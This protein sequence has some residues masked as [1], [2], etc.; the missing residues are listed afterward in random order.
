MK[1]DIYNIKKSLDTSKGKLSYYS[2]P[3]LEKQ[4]HNISKLPFSIRILLENALRNYDDFSVTKDHLKTVLNWTPEQSEKDVA[5]KPA[6][7]LMQDF[8]GV[9]AVVD[10]ASLRA[11]M[12][13]KGG[14]ASKINPLIPVDLV[15]DHSVQVD[16][17]AAQY[18][19]DKNIEEE[20]RR[21]KERY[22]FLKWAQQSFDNFSVVPPGMGICHQVN[23]EYFSKG[24]IARDGMVFPDTLV[25]TDSHTP[26]VNGIG[27]VAWGVGGI[28]AE[29]A[30]LGQPIYFISPEVI[31]LKLTGKL[32]L[33][34]TATDLVL[35]IANLL[36]KYGVVGKFVEVFGPGLDN[37][38]VPDRATIGNMSPEFGCTITYFPIDDKT[39]EYMRNSNRSEEQIK[40]V[41][42]YCKSNMLWRQDEDKIEYTDVVELDI[43]TVQPTVAGPKRPQDKIL[44][45]DLKE[46][47]IELEHAS[48]GRTY[49]EPSEREEAITRWKEEGGSQPT[50]QSHNP[51][52]DVEV[53]KAEMKNGLKTVWISQGNEKYMLSDGAVAIA[54]ITSCTNTSNPF[55]MIGAGL[56]AKKAREL[57]I[58]VKPWVKTSLAPGSKVVTDYLE[59]ADLLKDLEALQFHLVGYGCT[60]CIGNSGPLPPEIS[61]AVEENDLIVTSVLSG[62]RNFEARIH[63]QVKMNFLMSPMLVVAFAI[64]GRVDIDLTT[65]PL[66]CDRNGKKIYLKDIWP[67]DDEIHAVMSE[68]LTPKDFKKNYDEIF[69]GNEIWR[70]LEVPKDKLYQWEDD[71]TYIKEVP[72]FHNLSDDPQPLKNIEG[73]RALLMLGDSITTD[74]ISPAGAFSEDSAAGQYLI[75]RGVEKKSFNSYGSRRGNDEVM[76]R[77]TF[78]NVRIKNQLADKE[79]GYTKYLPTGEEMSVYDAAQKY[80]ADKTPLIVLTGKEYGS[81]SSRDWAAKGTILLGVK[82]VLAESYERIH[83]SNL[84]MMGVLPLEYVKGESAA[85]HGLTGNEVFSI[86]G[87]EN[88]LSPLKKV[89]VTAKTEDGKEIEFK[90]IARLDS[91]IEVA[92]Y[93]NEGI[94]QYVLRQFLK[95]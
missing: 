24:A 80:I 5:F 33:G 44:L 51:A 83:R 87:I 61:K 73:A 23:L 22:T 31:G 1:Q 19:Y 84:I 15:I 3:E 13:R 12:A 2:L 67:T 86:S 59:K 53:E 57:G 32:P 91:P 90:A 26:M 93:Q 20:Y 39:L 18:A 14:D 77:G 89:T 38:S 82:A 95:Q 92:Y 6:R 4:G 30:I 47:F 48:F 66:S 88:D 46:K 21:N 76:V 64:A 45:K 65:E 62:N 16:Y 8:T 36:R 68:V 50:K 54:A 49:I 42:E 58:D 34:S 75:S 74:H 72:F 79:G 35:T 71:S 81:G 25:G 56:V 85:S 52:P 78:A 63:S 10:I 37:L 60:S 94:L 40:L 70:N 9:P 28:E 27:V 17:F 7:V 11:E 29:A 43:S 69:E 41:E 55:V